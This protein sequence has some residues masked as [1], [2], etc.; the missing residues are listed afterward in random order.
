MSVVN[1][2]RLTTL[3]LVDGSYFS[4]IVRTSREFSQ[5]LDGEERRGTSGAGRGCTGESLV[6][7]RVLAVVPLAL[8]LPHVEHRPTALA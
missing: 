1:Q 7:P 2:A 4:E 3:A 5:D 8:R 6:D